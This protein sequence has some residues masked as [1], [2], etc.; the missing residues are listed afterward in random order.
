MPR[1]TEKPQR[2]SSLWLVEITG[3][4]N[5]TLWVH[6]TSNVRLTLISLSQV[7][8]SISVLSGWDYEGLIHNS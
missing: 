8:F 1:C 4:Y 7:F 6:L 5:A 3:K 2:A